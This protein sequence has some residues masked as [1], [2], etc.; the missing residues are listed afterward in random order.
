[1]NEKKAVSGAGAN[2]MLSM[3]RGIF[4]Y[5]LDEEL[6][7]TTPVVGIKM[8]AKL[9]SRT[10]TLSHDD[11]IELINSPHAIAK[12]VLVCS[13]LTCARVGELTRFRFDEIRT[14]RIGEHDVEVW[15]LPAEKSKNKQPN[16]IPLPD[17]VVD[18]LKAQQSPN[19]YIFGTRTGCIRVDSLS[20]WTARQ[21]FKWSPHD[22]RRTATTILARAGIDRW[23]ESSNF[24]KPHKLGPSPDNIWFEDEV[25]AWLEENTVTA[26]QVA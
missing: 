1:M 11:I 26:T 5:A 22:C 21:G 25:D 6:I 19:E 3:I 4:E 9:K 12:D 15:Y 14:E 17:L 18:I 23:I 13:L 7:V 8:P 2:K 24:P 10:R 20:T 16:I